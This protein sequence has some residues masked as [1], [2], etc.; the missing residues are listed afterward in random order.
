VTSITDNGVGDYTVNFTTAMSDANYS[1]VALTQFTNDNR[2]TFG[3][4]GAEIRSVTTPLT[5]S[6]CRIGTGRTFSPFSLDDALSVYVAIF[7]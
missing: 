2:A 7:R 5:T 4:M 1:V 3:A 6:A